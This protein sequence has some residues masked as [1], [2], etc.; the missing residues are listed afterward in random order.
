MNAD[1]R[2]LYIA[3]VWIILLGFLLG[4]AL[5]RCSGAIGVKLRSP[6]TLERNST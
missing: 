3:I 5:G 2:G 4:M 1:F 6:V